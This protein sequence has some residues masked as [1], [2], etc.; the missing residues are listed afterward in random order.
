MIA[1]SKFVVHKK[2][3][4]YTD[5]AF[6]P[7]EEARGSIVA[8]FDSQS[9]AAAAKH[10]AD[11]QSIRKLQGMNVVDFFFYSKQYDTIYDQ[12]QALYKTEFGEV[13][14]DKH[15]FNFPKQISTE[16]AKRFL[17]ILDVSFH[18]VVEYPDDEVL[19][20]AN[21]DLEEQELGEF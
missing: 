8:S 4:F 14:T 19:D 18:D 7:A 1:M 20:P 9:A 12:L 15:Y 17:T 6:E 13:I 11:I 21:F 3:F 10:E 2:G 5:E 16:Q